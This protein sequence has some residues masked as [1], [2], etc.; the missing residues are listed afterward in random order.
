MEYIFISIFIF[1]LLSV[2]A[3]SVKEK[4]VRKE[5]IYRL[6]RDGFIHIF[7]GS[8]L[9]FIAFNITKGLF[10]FGR[11]GRKGYLDR[12]ISYL[13]DYE[14]KWERNAQ[15]NSNKFLFYISD[16]EHF[17]HEVFYNENARQAEIEWAKLQAVYREC[18]SSQYTKIEKM[19]RSLS[20]DFFVSHASEDKNEFVRPLVNALTNLGL[21]VWYDEL[22]L[23]IGD[24]LRRNIDHG[25]SNSR[26]GIVVLSHAFF[27]KQWPQYELDALVNRSISGPKVIL[28]VWHGVQH[29]EVSEFSH[30]LAD[31]VAF[32]SSSLSIEDMALEFLKLIQRS[33]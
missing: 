16:I 12:P 25:L 17:M 21:R 18:V 22:T 29:R 32:S 14:W 23:E 24:S 1:A 8:G 2:V 7:H 6:E 20:Y 9:N 27:S 5:S 30:S 4:K 33:G 11:F 10:R 26:Y 19:E 13:I 28:P 3:I 31:K 15:K